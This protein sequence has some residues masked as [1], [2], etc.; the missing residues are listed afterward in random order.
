MTSPQPR[1]EKIDELRYRAGSSLAMV[2]GVQLNVFTTL[3]GEPMTLARMAHALDVRAVK[4]GPLLY[5]LVVAGLL[6]V[7]GELFS[8]IPESE[9]FLV[10]V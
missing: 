4:L 8:N 3:K 5:A 10:L 9:H 6:S 7:D 1:S 2:A